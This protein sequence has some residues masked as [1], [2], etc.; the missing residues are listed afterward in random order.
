MHGAI[1][2]AAARRSDVGRWRRV[3]AGG[4]VNGHRE[5]LRTIRMRPGDFEMSEH[6]TAAPEPVP[7]PAAAPASTGGT[8]ENCGSALL[9][10]YCYACGQPV[11]GLVRH[12]STIAGDF[13]DTVLNWDAR[14]PRTLWPLFV[15]PGWLTREY[16][17]GRRVRYVSPV[18]LFVTLAIVTFFVAQLMLSFGDNTFHFSDDDKPG[19]N[20]TSFSRVDTVEEVV[21]QRDEALAELAKAR[22]ENDGVP[23]VNAGLGIAEKQVRNSADARIAVLKRKAVDGKPSSQSPSK[24]AASVP[25]SKPPPEKASRDDDDDDN[26][27]FNGTPWDPKTNPLTVPWWPDFANQ[28]LNAQVG[29]GKKNIKR[30]KDDPELF[31][32]AF[33]SAVPSTLFVLLPVFALMLK[34]LYVFKRRLYME[35]LLV[36]LHS[37]AFLCLALLLMFGTVALQ[38]WLAPKGGAL[39]TLFN[40]LEA[41][42]WT[43]MPL[44]LLVMQKRVYDQGWIMTLLKYSVL[45]FC[46]FFLLV[47]GMVFTVMFSVVYA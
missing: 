43:W 39:H 11:K 32:D 9:G 47:L 15:K 20:D 30:M 17:A 23:G 19:V 4:Y 26:L 40:L 8:C 38:D 6:D 16:F 7:V 2:T 34:V 33:L 42:L 3:A 13:A 45:G 25:D 24:E 41:A 12:F 5:T 28:W 22:K 21:R 46:Y 37:H 14:L 27:S 36:A 44:Y 18:R 10:E 35:H 1:A 31:K 29:R